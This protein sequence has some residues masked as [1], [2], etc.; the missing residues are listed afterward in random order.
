MNT[1]CYFCNKQSTDSETNW[2]RN[3]AEIRSQHT[4]T[5]IAEFIRLFLGDFQS[6]RNIDDEY[7]YICSGCL[8][9]IDDYDWCRHQAME[10][11]KKLC[12][13]LL[14]TETKLSGIERLGSLD[15]IIDTTDNVKLESDIVATERCEQQPT[16]PQPSS[17][18]SSMSNGNDTSN[19]IPVPQKSKGKLNL[20]LIN[21]TKC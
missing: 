10:H 5:P 17:M 1:I 20:I 3:F 15:T 2:C 19:L 11:E 12:N 8:E 6:I 14:T 13:L 7:N 4:Q 9:Q 18:L 21:L 16:T